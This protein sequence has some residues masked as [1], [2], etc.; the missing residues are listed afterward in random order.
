MKKVTAKDVAKR[1]GVSPATVSMIL[2]NKGNVSF[3]AETI[4]RVTRAARQ[5]NYTVPSFA[6]PSEHPRKNL[7]ALFM[8]TLNNPYYPMVNQTVE[9][10]VLPHG[11]HLIIYNIH[12]RSDIEKYYLDVL[13]ED[14]VDGIV[15]TFSPTFPR[16]LEREPRSVWPN[17]CG[18]RCR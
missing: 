13:V 6:R 9:E 8:A 5:L 12:K 11:Y 10:N 2:N 18:R 16:L 3:S 14:K 4:E 7:I 17:P 1:A 15:Y